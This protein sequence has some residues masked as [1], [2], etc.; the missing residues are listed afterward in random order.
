MINYILL[1][2]SY[3][4]TE[5]SRNIESSNATSLFIYT[6]LYIINQHVQFH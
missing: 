1:L 3:N 2:P 5:D 4:T 6:K